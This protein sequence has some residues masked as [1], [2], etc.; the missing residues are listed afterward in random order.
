M[1]NK[2]ERF[3][4]LFNTF[5]G[6]LKKSLNVNNYLSYSRLL[7]EA[8]K[9]DVY[10]KRKKELL[11]RIGSLRNVLVHE[12]GN[13]IIS[14]PTDE[15]LNILEEIVNRYIKPNLVYD[16]CHENVFIIKNLQTLKVALSIMEKRGFSKL[17]V[18]EDGRCIG[19][20][21]GN[22]ISRWLRQNI[23][24]QSELSDLLERTL[25]KSVMAYQKPKD[26]IH[27]ISRDINVNEFVTMVSQRPSPS[28]VYIM[29]EHG[30]D[31][32]KPLTIITSYDYPKIF[33]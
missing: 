2:T 18:Y 14:V 6:A 8:S 17:P 20:L 30:V 12:E 21:T 16:L 11:E 33:G 9:R 29:T 1:D 13:V 15:T 5:E 26:H 10:I 3:L 24:N 22:M 27:F 31:S 28:G 7:I 32:E 23:Y 19:L 25:I 4:Q